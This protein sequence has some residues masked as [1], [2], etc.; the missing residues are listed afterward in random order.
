M[1]TPTLNTHNP[2]PTKEKAP[3]VEI[4]LITPTSTLV[5]P[6][7]AQIEI[8]CLDILPSLPE[9]AELEGSIFFNSAVGSTSPPF[10][11]DMQT[12]EKILLPE[13][14]SDGMYFS[15]N[16]SQSLLAYYSFRTGED[17]LVVMSF[18]GQEQKVANWNFKK[19][20]G[21]AY[22]LDNKNLAISFREFSPYE[23]APPI[24]IVNIR[25]G[26]INE[27]S[28]A[29]PYVSKSAA[30][31]Y[32]WI[33]STFYNPTITKVAYIAYRGNSRELV[34]WDLLEE[35]IIGEI[36]PWQGIFDNPKWSPDSK[37]LLTINDISSEQDISKPYSE[38]FSMSYDGEEKRLTQLTSYYDL[39]R[40][41]NFEWSPNSRYVAFWIV[42]E[43]TDLHETLAIMDLEKNQVTNYCIPGDQWGFV[44][45]PPVWS[46]NSQQ[47]IIDNISEESY[48]ISREII[49]DIEEEY[50][51]V[52][53][54][55]M[56]PDAWL[57]NSP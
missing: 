30:Y 40:I 28:G 34:L 36:S 42:D 23:V 49:I 26:I 56:N 2:E 51:A 31:D 18:D 47:I 17:R 38:F 16:P 39:P 8:N 32:R 13:L 43:A 1:V 45:G 48:L 3:T 33:T 10:L 24:I 6:E 15:M 12:G 14:E 46:P 25:T 41:G 54:E 57:I 37:R 53:A 55:N 11:L 29:Y 50:A 52:I 22:W 4:P 44:S 21:I 7:Y 35:K 20:Q 27:F 19:W 5:E 9:T